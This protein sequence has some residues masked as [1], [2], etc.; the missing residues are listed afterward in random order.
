MKWHDHLKA[1]DGQSVKITMMDLLQAQ[2]LHFTH[3]EN[4]WEVKKKRYFD[5][6]D[7]ETGVYLNLLLEQG[8]LRVAKNELVSLGFPREAFST[9][10]PLVLVKQLLRVICNEDD[11]ILDSFAGSGTTAHAVLALNKEDGGNRK[12]IMIE[13]MEYANDITAERVRRVITGVEKVKDKDL[14]N[15]LGG[16][17]TYCTP[18]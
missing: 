8:S 17:F 2:L 13:C 16:T 1:N 9:P 12:F 4:G 7:P 3:S 14:Q 11:T 10:K 15:G 18:R 6:T 5:E